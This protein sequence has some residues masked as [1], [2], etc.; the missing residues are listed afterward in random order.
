[1]T[2]GIRAMAKQ[3]TAI[4]LLQAVLEAELG[5]REITPPLIAEKLDWLLQA[6]PQFGIDP[7]EVDRQA[8]IDEMVR[9]FSLWIGRDT[10]LTS[11]TGH[12]AWL[13]SS[14]KKGWRYWPRYREWLDTRLSARVID[15]M[16]RSTD[17]VLELL[18]DPLRPGGWDRRGLVVGN[19]QSGKTGHYIGLVCKAADAGYKI[20]IVLAGLHNNLRS[21]TQMRLDEGFLGYETRPKEEDIEAIG[22]GRIDG[23]PAIRPNFATNRTNNGDFTTRV[24]TNL[25]ISPE[26]RPLAVRGQKEQDRAGTP[27]SVDP[28]PRCGPP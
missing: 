14:R 27:A 21:Q 6:A 8:T 3:D 23:D 12:E 28:E 26:Q 15:A 1:M 4:K 22:V 20:V 7:D 18:E 13:V 17:G 16:D 9:R 11:D 2:R 19:I 10:M 24:A 25:G 5:K